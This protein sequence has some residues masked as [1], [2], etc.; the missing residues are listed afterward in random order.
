[1]MFS[2]CACAQRLVRTSLL[3]AGLSLGRSPEVGAEEAEVSVELSGGS[4][5]WRG[6]VRESVAAT[7]LGTTGGMGASYIG[8]FMVCT[9]L[10]D[11]DYRDCRSH[12]AVFAGAVLGGVGSGYRGYR[13]GPLALVFG[14]VFSGGVLGAVSAEALASSFPVY[15]G[16]ASGGYLGYRLWRMREPQGESFSLLPTWSEKRLGVLLSGRF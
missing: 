10:G 8:G 2:K 1:M 6:T 7:L 12:P 3:L 15:L 13:N 16:A 5:A 14:G 4:P 11:R 9:V